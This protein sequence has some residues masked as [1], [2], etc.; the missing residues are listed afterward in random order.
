MSLLE[1]MDS[2]S[3]THPPLLNQEFT[4]RR[5]QAQRLQQDLEHIHSLLKWLQSYNQAAVL[6]LEPTQPLL[7]E[8]GLQLPPFLTASQ[9]QIH[10]T[11]LQTLKQS[12]LST[13]KS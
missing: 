7:R 9:L 10:L 4:D 2:L 6:S 1:M 12:A 8:L 13:L 5:I 11:S 3:L